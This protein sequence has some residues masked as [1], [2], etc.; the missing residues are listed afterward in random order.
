MARQEAP[1][2]LSHALPLDVY[3]W[4]SQLSKH[5]TYSLWPPLPAYLPHKAQQPQV[6]GMDELAA[7]GLEACRS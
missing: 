2:R 4:V 6:E 1:Q 7:S 3:T 5:M